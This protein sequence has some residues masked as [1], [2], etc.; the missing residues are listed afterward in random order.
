MTIRYRGDLSEAEH[1]QLAAL[2]NGGKHA[3][4]KI[5]RAQILLIADAGVSDTVIANSI[6]VGVL[7]VY[8]ARRRFV[9]G[10]LDLA[11]SE[12][13]RPGPL[14]SCVARRRRCWW[15]PLAPTHPW[16]ANAGRPNCWP[17]RW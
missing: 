7:T 5:K 14:A 10:N 15:P 8:R 4:R 6:A 1:A 16:G 2:L 12:E 13:A 9:A 11:L 17:M 3:A